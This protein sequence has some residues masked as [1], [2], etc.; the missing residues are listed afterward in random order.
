MNE[1]LEMTLK[2]LIKYVIITDAKTEFIENMQYH[3]GEE[4][5]K[6]DA[7]ANNLNHNCVCNM[8]LYDYGVIG[9]ITLCDNCADSV[10]TITDEH[11]KKALIGQLDLIGDII[12]QIAQLYQEL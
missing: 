10:F 12:A 9:K 3:E 4:N 5:I 11:K 8:N 6:C 2:C 1:V 7:C